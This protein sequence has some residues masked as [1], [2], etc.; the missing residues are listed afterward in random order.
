MRLSAGWRSQR[1][2]S[3]TV[4]FLL[5]MDLIVGRHV[6]R[7]WTG[8]AGVVLRRARTAGEHQVS[9]WERIRKGRKDVLALALTVHDD[10]VQSGYKE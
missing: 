1:R 7:V 8:V 4:R 10:I 5:S 6:Y 3:R 9:A 2:P